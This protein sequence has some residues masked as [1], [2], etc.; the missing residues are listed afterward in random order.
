[1]VFSQISCDLPALPT[2]LQ[3]S[4][5]MHVPVQCITG[6]MVI[7]FGCREQRI[8]SDVIVAAGNKRFVVTSFSLQETS[9][10]RSRWFRCRKQGIRGD[11]IATAGNKGFAAIAFRENAKTEIL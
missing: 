4:C 6:E 10:L 9:G 1:M 3:F 7:V 5:K 2:F 8:S 11:V